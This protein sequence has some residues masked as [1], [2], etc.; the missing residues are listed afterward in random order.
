MKEIKDLFEIILLGFCAVSAVFISSLIFGEPSFA[1]GLKKTIISIIWGI[2]F[3][4]FTGLF[5]VGVLEI[6]EKIKK[7][8][9]KK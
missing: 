8:F 4:L 7:K 6:I 9:K 2:S 3:F 1:G 5:Y